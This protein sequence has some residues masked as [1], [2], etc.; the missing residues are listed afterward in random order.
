[1]NRVKQAL[2]LVLKNQT[3]LNKKEKYG[4]LVKTI[5]EILK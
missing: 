3:L 4:E 1:M 5:I 2:A